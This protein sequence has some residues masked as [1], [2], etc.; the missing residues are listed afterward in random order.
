MNDILI[1]KNN[2]LF[3]QAEHKNKKKIYLLDLTKEF[4]DEQMTASSPDFVEK[5]KQM[6]D[7]LALDF[8]KKKVVKKYF[9]DQSY[10]K[11]GFETYQG[12]TMLGWDKGGKIR[13]FDIE[14]FDFLQIGVPFNE[15]QQIYFADDA[16]IY[17]CPRKDLFTCQVYK[18]NEQLE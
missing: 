2:Q 3:I 18:N 5:V 9:L 17:V 14:K 13:F 7:T 15:Y 10:Q 6:K 16:Y 4:P 11:L 8:K 1:T 12:L